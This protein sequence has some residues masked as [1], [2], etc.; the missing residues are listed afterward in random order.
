MSVSF[1]CGAWSDDEDDDDDDDE[2]SSPGSAY[3]DDLHL[4]V[5]TLIV[6]PSSEYM[7]ESVMGCGAFGTVVHC[8]NVSNNDSVALKIIME[9]KFNVDARKEVETL[10]LL[11]NFNLEKYNIVKW[12]GS[13]VHE[14]HYCHE[15]EKLDMSLYQYQTTMKACL[16]LRE[17]R[18][19]LQQ[20]ALSLQLLKSL[21]IAHTDLKPDNIMLVDHVHQPLRVKVIDFGTAIL[22]SDRCKG[23]ELQT[24]WFRSPEIL[25]GA[26]FNEAIDIW[27]LGCIAAE[28]F[29]GKALFPS[30]DEFDMMRH[31]LRI[32]GKPPNHLLN[33]G[34]YTKQFFQHYSARSEQKKPDLW[35]FR[36]YLHT[37]ACR[38]CTLNSLTDLLEGSEELSGEDARADDLDKR[39]FVELLVKMLQLDPTERIKPQ[40]LLQ[41]PFITMSHLVGDFTD[42]QYVKS[43]REL[44]NEHLAQSILNQGDVQQSETA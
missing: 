40:Q 13:F 26:S 4:D 9:T 8:K 1:Y 7:V 11:K 20:V 39:S 30:N 21:G 36:S 17:I 29:M 42:C 27:S 37:W 3:G 33:T 15:F 25:L 2:H 32:I 38:P 43:S 41:H 14:G 24:L 28:L 5:G 6:S 44:L 10:E 19:I 16:E 23:P 35:I 12:Y 22:I 34:A 31:I 18:P